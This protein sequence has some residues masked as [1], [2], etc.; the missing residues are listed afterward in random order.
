MCR[1]VFGSKTKDFLHFFTILCEGESDCAAQDNASPF[2]WIIIILFYTKHFVT[3]VS[4]FF[5]PPKGNVL[6]P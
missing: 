2:M 1:E 5:K 4:N 6:N 3:P